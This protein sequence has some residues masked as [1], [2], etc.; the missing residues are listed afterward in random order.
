MVDM[1]L[2]LS[3][4]RFFA[5]QHDTTVAVLLTAMNI[6]NDIQPPFAAAVMIELFNVCGQFAVELWYKNDTERDSYQ[7]VI[8]GRHIYM[9]YRGGKRNM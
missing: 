5:G 2:S 7:L 4:F 9:S 6:F 1:C 8:P 3:L